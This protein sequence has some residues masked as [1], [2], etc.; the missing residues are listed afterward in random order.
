L[1]T[2]E[3]IGYNCNLLSK[4]QK[5]FVLKVMNNEEDNLVLNK[6]FKELNSF[7]KEFQEF[8]VS[9]VKKYNSESQYMNNNWIY[10]N[11]NIRNYNIE[12]TQVNKAEINKQSNTSFNF[13]S[14]NFVIS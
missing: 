5:I 7:F 12:I 13:S 3:S 1:D 10:N 2:A 8:V 11:S 6:S 14:I 4:N 9:L